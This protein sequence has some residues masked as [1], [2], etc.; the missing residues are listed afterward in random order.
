MMNNDSLRLLKDQNDVHKLVN[1]INHIFKDKLNK[2]KFNP[3]KSVSS[4][5]HSF[6][7]LYE[8]ISQ[9]VDCNCEICKGRKEGKVFGEEYVCLTPENYFNQSNPI[10]YY[11]IDYY[12]FI[13]EALENYYYD[14]LDSVAKF[15]ENNYT[16]ECFIKLCRSKTE[17]TPKISYKNRLISLNF[18][19]VTLR[20]L[21]KDENQVFR[22]NLAPYYSSD[23]NKFEIIITYS[24]NNPKYVFIINTYNEFVKY[25]KP[26][27]ECSM[28]T[29]C[30]PK[31]YKIL[32]LIFKN[33]FDK[34]RSS[35]KKDLLKLREWADSPHLQKYEMK[36]D[37]KGILVSRSKENKISDIMEYIP[38]ISS[39][40][41]YHN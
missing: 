2:I 29:R 14:I 39:Y 20:V 13:I 9:K 21:D 22:C 38:E 23:T 3:Q 12:S 11:P 32:N 17:F 35:Y 30:I 1:F 25:L 7:D 28:F 5:T 34:T 18:L 24:T 4:L 36:F 33:G 26:K 19:A 37:E 6:D 16:V 40:V 41:L 8:G 27:Y 10:G 31:Y 15:E